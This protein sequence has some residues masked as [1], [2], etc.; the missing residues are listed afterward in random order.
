MI[1]KAKMGDYEKI[2]SFVPMMLS[3]AIFPT[4]HKRVCAEVLGAVQFG[5][6]IVAE[7][8]GDIIGTAGFDI[9]EPCWYA[10]QRVLA[11]KWIAVREDHQGRFI[12]GKLILALENEAKDLGIPFMPTVAGNQ[13]HAST[14][15]KRYGDP[16]AVIY[17]KA[18]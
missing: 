17:K 8:E 7:H 1:R 11:D 16:V 14:F 9:F 3:Q 13:K 12:A 2:L 15:T 6:C 5:N 10:S 18:S 4:D